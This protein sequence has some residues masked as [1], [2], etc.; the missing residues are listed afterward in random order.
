ML[1]LAGI[2]AAFFATQNT[3][4]TSLTLGNYHL[5]NIPMYLIVLGSVLIGLLVAAIINLINSLTSSFELLGKDSKIKEGKKL[6]AELTKKIHQ[7]EL[8]NTEL[9]TLH[10][11]IPDEKSI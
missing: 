8:E 3:T 2:G 7:L 11:K 9:K 4:L 5:R 10:E 6:V 1:V